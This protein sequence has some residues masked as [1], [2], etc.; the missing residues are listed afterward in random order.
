MNN[1]ILSGNEFGFSQGKNAELAVFHLIVKILPAFE[2]ASH[3]ICVFLD[4]SACFDTISRDI[5]CSKL[6]RYRVRGSE[7]NFCKCY[8]QNRT[9]FVTYSSVES[10]VRQQYIV[11]ILKA[12]N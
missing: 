1:G 9:Q 8:F 6:Y 11:T 5:L 7:L 2:L 12:Q 4:F 3:C 10:F